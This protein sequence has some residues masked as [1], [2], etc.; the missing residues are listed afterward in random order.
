MLQVCRACLLECHRL[1]G[2][3]LLGCIIICYYANRRL[4]ETKKIDMT[5]HAG[6]D[7]SQILIQ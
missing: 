2:Y 1:H 7:S 3:L 5:N 6:R 4:A